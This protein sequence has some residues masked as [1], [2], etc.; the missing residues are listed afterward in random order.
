MLCVIKLLSADVY[1]SEG[2]RG[3]C[4]EIRLAPLG[5]KACE[6]RIVQYR[7]HCGRM[8]RLIGRTLG[9]TWLLVAVIHAEISDNILIRVYR[10][11]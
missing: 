1:V 5:P 8:I 9:R 6:G 11:R 4:I 3:D 7:A 10:R 2:Q